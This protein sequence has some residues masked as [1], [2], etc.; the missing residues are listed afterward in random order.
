MHTLLTTKTF[1]GESWV[2]VRDIATMA[3]QYN[4]EIVR[5]TAENEQLRSDAKRY[6]HLKSRMIAVDFEWGELKEPVLVFRWDGEISAD[7]DKT[8][9]AAIERAKQ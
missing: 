1:D 5:L 7:L 8:T 4:D 2:N 6:Q 9:D 3:A